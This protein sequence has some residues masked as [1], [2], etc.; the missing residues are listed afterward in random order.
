MGIFFV[1]VMLIK[2]DNGSETI[3][4]LTHKVLDKHYKVPRIDLL[5]IKGDIENKQKFCS[6]ESD[7]LKKDVS[8][9][10]YD[11]LQNNLR[12]LSSFVGKKR[13]TVLY[14]DFCKPTENWVCELSDMHKYPIIFIVTSKQKRKLLSYDKKTENVRYEE[15]GLRT[16]VVEVY[17]NKRSLWP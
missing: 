14:D 13:K 15:I 8:I 9:F 6:F 10:G 3:K 4:T 16:T 17:S 5:K 7:T 1:G 12:D 11:T 2:Y